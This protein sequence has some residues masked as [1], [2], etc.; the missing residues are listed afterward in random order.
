[1]SR[2]LAAKNHYPAIDVLKSISRVCNRVIGQEH[3]AVAGCLRQT[4]AKAEELQVL[5]DFGEYVPGQD[6]VNDAVFTCGQQINQ[7]LCQELYDKTTLDT[8]LEYMHAIVS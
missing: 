7:L 2:K 8:T 1:M 6:P 4:L 3:L 5:I